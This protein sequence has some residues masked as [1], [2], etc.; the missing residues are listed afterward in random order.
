MGTSNAQSPAPSVDLTVG[1]VGLCSIQLSYGRGEPGH[2]TGDATEVKGARKRSYVPRSLGLADRLAYFTHRPDGDGNDDCWL[3][4]GTRD[5]DGYGRVHW[6]GTGRQAH[7]MALELRLGRA[8]RADEVTRHRA[9]CS[10]LCVRPTHLQPGTIADNV[11]DMVV[12]GTHARGERI[13][14]AKLTAAQVL[15]IRAGGA[16]QNFE[17]VGRAYGISGRAVSLIVAGKRWK[18][19]PLAPSHLPAPEAS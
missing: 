5:G 4:L 6:R 19:L 8:L 1:N 13:A 12:A 15:A 7:R 9:S 14:S 11:Q 2:V 3:W 16:G 10:R 18:H 17:A